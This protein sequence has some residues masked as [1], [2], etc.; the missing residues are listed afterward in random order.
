MPV[1]HPYWYIF[2]VIFE[3]FDEHP[4]HVRMGVPPTLTHEMANDIFLT[5]HV[6]QY[7][8]SSVQFNID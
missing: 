2:G 5:T 6:N 3:N 8:Y 7:L 4:R 1:P